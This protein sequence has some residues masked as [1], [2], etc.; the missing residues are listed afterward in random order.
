MM[1]VARKM[2]QVLNL[3]T[4]AVEWRMPGDEVP[5]AATWPGLAH[6]LHRG[7]IEGSPPDRVTYPALPTLIEE[8]I[9][10]DSSAGAR[11]ESRRQDE[12]ESGRLRQLEQQVE[13]DR[14]H[15]LE[16]QVEL[17]QQQPPEPPKAKPAKS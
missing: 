5:E 17:E 8:N 1:Y 13:L 10:K 11:R 3:E 7:D 15:E 9:G 12:L 2:M 14:L 6:Y 16:Q 4:N